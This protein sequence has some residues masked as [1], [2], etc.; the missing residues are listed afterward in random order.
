M[1]SATLVKGMSINAS[2]NTGNVLSLALTCLLIEH[3]LFF[4]LTALF[5]SRI[6]TQDDALAALGPMKKPAGTALLHDLGARET[7]ELAEAIWA[8]DYGEPL[9]N[10]SVSQ[11]EITI[12][13]E[14]HTNDALDYCTV[15]NHNVAGNHSQHMTAAIHRNVYVRFDTFSLSNHYS[16]KR[17]MWREE[18]HSW[19]CTL[20]HTHINTQRL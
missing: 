16:H 14:R 11:D 4:K 15:Q 5:K 17:S 12:C 9:C 1:T 19:K 8:V 10:L 18:E 20:A 3:D 6:H 13:Q 7:R 2:A